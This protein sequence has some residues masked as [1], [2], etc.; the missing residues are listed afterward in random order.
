MW[1]HHWGLGEKIIE[2]HRCIAYQVYRCGGITDWELTVLPVVGLL[3][4]MNVLD[5]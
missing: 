1:L 3:G 4:G 5:I 2:D